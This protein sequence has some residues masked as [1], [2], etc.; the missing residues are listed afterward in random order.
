MNDDREERNDIYLPATEVNVTR[1]ERN[2]AVMGNGATNTPKQEEPK[3]PARDKERERKVDRSM[4]RLR[5]KTLEY[6][7]SGSI[8]SLREADAIVSDPAMRQV[9]RDLRHTLKGAEPST[10]RET[11]NGIHARDY[12][13]ETA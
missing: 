7:E 12:I 5:A 4:R 11:F 13:Y 3:A 9:T 6:H 10:I 2:A 8:W 1:P